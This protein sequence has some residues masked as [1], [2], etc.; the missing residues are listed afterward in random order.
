MKAFIFDIDG[1]LL[2]SEDA[3]FM[4]FNDILERFG[5]KK[6]SRAELMKYRGNTTQNWLKYLNLGL[7]E[8]ELNNMAHYGE[9][10]YANWFIPKHAKPMKN[11][12]ETLE[13]LKQKNAVLAVVTNQKKEEVLQS[14]KII[15][16]DKFDMVV[17]SKMIKKPKP[18]PE[19]IFLVID[20]LKLKKEDVL[21]IGDSKVDVET[22]KNADINY[23]LVESEF[24]KELDG[25]KIAD[26]SELKK[27]LM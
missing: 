27:Y 23:V 8:S 19:S 13:Y 18:D 6:K 20:G 10:R 24:N 17:D 16:F 2:D 14:L 11:A 26:L 3:V 1:T 25:K 7:K 4:L 15:G 21:Y 9:L 12:K 5:F 22:A